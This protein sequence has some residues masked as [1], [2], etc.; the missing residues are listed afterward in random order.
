M[1][2][3]ILLISVIAFTVVSA[4]AQLENSSKEQ[5]SAIQEAFGKD[6]RAIVASL[7]KLQGKDSVTFWGLYDNF[8]AERM[9][10]GLKKVELFKKY[11]AEYESLDDKSTNEL[12]NEMMQIVDKDNKM[13]IKHHSHINKALGGIV[14]GQFYQIEMY[15]QASVRQFY[16]D[17][18]DF[19]GAE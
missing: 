16:F 1:K 19:I 12:V 13:I 6:K 8:E 10:F 18:L 11:K 4:F 5:V 2:K 7:V 14:A 9:E 3:V 15:I 17:Q